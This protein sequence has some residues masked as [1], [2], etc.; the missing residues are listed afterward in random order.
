MWSETEFHVKDALKIAKKETINH[1]RNKLGFLIDT[2]TS[3]GGNTDT[4]GI[5]ERFFSRESREDVCILINKKS[6]RDAFSKLL[7][8]YDMVLSVCQNRV[9]LARS[10]L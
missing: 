7:G 3:G 4:G 6:D 8:M 5:A 1:I 9:M 10:P 2:P